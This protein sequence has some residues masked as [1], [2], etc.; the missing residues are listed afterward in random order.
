MLSLADRV[1]DMLAA[2]VGSAWQRNRDGAIVADRQV[3]VRI[4]LRLVGCAPSYDE[5]SLRMLINGRPLDDAA[6]LAAWLRID[7]QYGFR[8]TRD[9][10]DAVLI[11]EARRNSFHPVRAYLDGLHWDGV[12]RIDR[13]LK[14]YCGAKDNKFIRGVGR[15]ALIAAVRRVRQPGCVVDEM[16]VLVDERQSTDKS[17][18]LRA[19]CPDPAWFTDSLHLGGGDKEAIARLAGK[20]IVEASEPAGLRRGDIDSMEA[21]LSRQ[22]DPARRAYR[23]FPTEAPR[24]CVFIGTT[25]EPVFLKDSENRRYWLVRAGRFDAAAI[26][27]DRDQLWAEAAAAEAEGESI[28]LDRKLWPRTTKL[29]EE[30]AV[31]PW[32]YTIE[33]VLGNMTGRIATAS[34]FEILMLP[35]GVKRPDMSSRLASCMRELGWDNNQG[36]VIKIGGRVCRGYL[37]GTGNERWHEITVSVDPIARKATAR[38]RARA[39]EYEA[40]NTAGGTKDPANAPGLD[41]RF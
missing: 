18:A 25:K 24:Q 8:P 7:E 39:A 16:L 23:R 38:V 34:L 9:F 6:S 41:V 27:R 1:Q 28:R 21:F 2:G 10:F 32:L 33:E 35:Q 5:F 26:A 20:W 3:N 15:L 13:W 29:Q 14:T 11:N 17:S 4:A 40:A 31:D 22:V 19:L 12:P 36:K 37:R 30:Q